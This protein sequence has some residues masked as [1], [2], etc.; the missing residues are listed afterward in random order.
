MYAY[1]ILLLEL[2]TGRPAVKEKEGGGKECLLD[3][4]KPLLRKVATSI[5]HLMDE[6][7]K[8]QWEADKVAAGTLAHIA[9][10]CTKGDKE[11]RPTMKDVM[12]M[13]QKVTLV[14]EEHA[15]TE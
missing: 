5:H 11:Q 13:L 4:A 1:G 12:E 3:W 2:L 14:K 8:G 6:G 7:L 15:R 10:R 9:Y